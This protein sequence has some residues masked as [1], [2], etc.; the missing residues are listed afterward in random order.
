[1]SQT[2]IKWTA[3]LVAVTFFMENLDATIITAVLPALAQSFHTTAIDLNVGISA[4]LLAFAIFISISGWMVDHFGAR[5]IFVS[6]ALFLIPQF[7][8]D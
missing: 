3:L 2:K 6:T 1:M 5:T 8:S 7:R 4:H